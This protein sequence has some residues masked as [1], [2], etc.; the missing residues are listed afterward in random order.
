MY[1]LARQV[2]AIDHR[3]APSFRNDTV[4]HEENTFSFLMANPL[5]SLARPQEYASTGSRMPSS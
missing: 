3:I 4:R 2:F 5:K 1:I